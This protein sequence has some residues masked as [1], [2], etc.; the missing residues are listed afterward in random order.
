MLVGQLGFKQV[1]VDLVMNILVDE[2]IGANEAI[3]EQNNFNAAMASKLKCL[4]N[5]IFTGKDE[6]VLFE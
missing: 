2:I 6:T 5:V 1:V 4:L 3:E